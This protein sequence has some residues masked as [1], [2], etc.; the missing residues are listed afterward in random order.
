MTDDAMTDDAMT[1]VDGNRLAGTLQELFAVDVTMAHGQCGTCG[2]MGMMA[3]AKVYDHA[4][5]MVARCASCDAVLMRV[6]RSPERAWLDM[7]GLTCLEFSLP[8]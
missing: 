5:G 4:A 1:Y 2:R 7:R 3:E 6:V 8:G